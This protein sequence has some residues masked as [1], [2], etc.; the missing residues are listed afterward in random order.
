M[1]L[2]KSL[3]AA[4]QEYWNARDR[5]S[6]EQQ[7]RG[8][9]DTGTRGSVTGGL[10][11]DP[12]VDL[13]VRII[14]Q[15]GVQES[16]IK[17]GS[18]LELPGY[19]RAEKKWDLL[20]ISKNQL[21]AAIEFK[22]QAGRSIGNNINNRAEEVIGIAA[23]LWVAYREGR[24]RESPQPFIGYFFLFEDAPENKRPIRCQEPY[25]SVDPVF[26]DTSYADRYE[27]LCKRLV[28]ER[29]YTAT[30]LTLSTRPGPTQPMTR[31]SHPS[32]ELSFERFVRILEGHLLPFKTR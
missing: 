22:S 24:F 20:V 29:L 23:D 15:S 4:V 16:E 26:K 25:F 12:L 28:L 9:S 27:I 21:I 18:R 17:R 2:A 10:H 1:N 6:Q 14:Q 31:I 13:I 5:Q 19:Y 7:A 30:C 32:P 3:K 11:M 8:T